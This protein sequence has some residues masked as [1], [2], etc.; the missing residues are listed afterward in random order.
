MDMNTVVNLL[1]N[2]LV[3]K[4]VI[5]I[6]SLVGGVKYLKNRAVQKWAEVAFRAVE[7]FARV[8]AEK[9]NTVKTDDKINLFAQKFREFMKRAGWWVVTDNDVTQAKNIASAVN[10]IYTKGSEAISSATALAKDKADEPAGGTG[11]G[12]ADPDPK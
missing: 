11:G 3:Q 10:L 4:I 8:D 12:K 5:F 1:N 6:I 2:E 9:G 7:E